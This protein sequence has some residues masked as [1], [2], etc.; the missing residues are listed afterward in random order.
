M[1]TVRPFDACLHIGLPKTATTLLQA[2][3]FPHHPEV[4]YLGKYVESERDGPQPEEA[5]LCVERAVRKPF[6]DCD[7]DA[8]SLAFEAQVGADR[9]AGKLLVWSSEDLTVGSRER[10]RA[11]AERLH[12][13]LGPSR[14]VLTVRH[15]VRLLE[16]LYLQLVRA[17]VVGRP[18]KVGQPWDVPS[19]EAWLEAHDALPERGALGHI[20]YA[21]TLKIYTDVFGEDAVRVFVFEE[22][23]SAPEAFV[24]SLCR[25]LQIDADLGLAAL[26]GE[27]RNDRWTQAQF[28]HLVALHQTRLGR[29][30]VRFAPVGFRRWYFEQGQKTD[31]PKAS[32]QLP[33]DWSARILEETAAGHRW[34]ADRWGVPLAEWGYPV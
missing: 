19:P 28:D 14:I 9:A 11:R 17:N 1:T 32:A 18:A 27:R 34:M 29:A 4:T 13:L 23:V 21:E 30:A 8:L 24:A 7:M 33:A 26:E 5:R 16:S 6:Q 25:F 2:K 3:L 10:R 15:P 31:G 12:R 22:L 20:D